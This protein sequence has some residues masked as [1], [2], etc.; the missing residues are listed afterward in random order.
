MQSQLKGITIKTSVLT[1]NGKLVLTSEK[2]D[3]YVLSAVEGRIRISEY[4]E[5]TECEKLRKLT[6]AIMINFGQ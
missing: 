5:Q 1:E 3:V 6:E 4:T 2:N